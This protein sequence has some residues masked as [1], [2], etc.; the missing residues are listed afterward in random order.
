[1]SNLIETQE[2]GSRVKPLYVSVRNRT[3]KERLAYIRELKAAS[4]KEQPAKFLNIRTLI[5]RI[6]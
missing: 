2:L 1:M 5:K 6:V 4:Q 3:L